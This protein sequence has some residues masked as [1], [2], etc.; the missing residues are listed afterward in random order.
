V[1]AL[2]TF[3][4]SYLDDCQWYLHG[5][6]TIQIESLYGSICKCVDKG[7]H[8]T[9]MYTPLVDLS[10]IEQ[11]DGTAIPPSSGLD[12]YLFALAA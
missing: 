5:Y 7:R 1:A 3:I 12:S 9:V 8:W 6:N 4:N 10:I 11:N 2:L